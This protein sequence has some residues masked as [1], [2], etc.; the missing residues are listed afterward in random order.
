VP[1]TQHAICRFGLSVFLA[2][3]CLTKAGAVAEEKYPE[4]IQLEIF[5]GGF[6]L[7][8]ERQREGRRRPREVVVESIDVWAA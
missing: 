4:S 5:G 1:P 6:G 3:C 7:V 8:V 2:S